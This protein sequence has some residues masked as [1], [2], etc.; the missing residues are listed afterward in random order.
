[1]PTSTSLGHIVKSMERKASRVMTG[2][3]RSSAKFYRTGPY[4]SAQSRAVLGRLKAA[5][6]AR[7]MTI[8]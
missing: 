8:H 3:Q 2:K 1:M 6:R 5:G 4:G 7:G